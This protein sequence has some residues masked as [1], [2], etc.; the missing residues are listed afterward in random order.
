MS[1]IHGVDH[2][3]C[4]SHIIRE[5]VPNDLDFVMQLER[6]CFAEKRQSSKRSL[7]NSISSASQLVL[8]IETSPG[9]KNP[10]KWVQP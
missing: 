6:E 1:L 5:A 3:S 8:I 4:R 9:R 2:T 10:L 7:Q